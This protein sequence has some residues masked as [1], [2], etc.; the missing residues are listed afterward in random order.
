M[1][2]MVSMMVGGVRDNSGYVSDEGD[3]RSG[4]I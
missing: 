3:V 4:S 1:V 2:T